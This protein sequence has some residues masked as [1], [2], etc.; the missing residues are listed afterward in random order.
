MPPETTEQDIPLLKEMEI[1]TDLPE[2]TTSKDIVPTGGIQIIGSSNNV[3]KVLLD[4][5]KK[6]T[7]C[8]SQDYKAIDDTIPIL[9]MITPKCNVDNKYSL[10]QL[11]T[12]SKY[13]TE[14]TVTVEQI[15]EEAFKERLEK[16]KHKFFEEEIKKCTRKI[17]TLLPEPCSTLKEFKTLYRDTCKANFLTVDIDKKISKIQ[18]EINQLAD[19]FI[20]SS[21]SLSVFEQ[22]IIGF[23]EELLKLERDKERIK[24]KAKDLK[25]KLSPKLDYLASLRKEIFDA[26]IQG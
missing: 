3:T 2:V 15:K 8:S 11:D 6:I 18:E 25:W 21:D 20:N 14:N 13:I 26:L 23:E 19:N 7:D 4:S 5:I 1:Q 10:S 12:L 22:K 16:E 17:D 24:G 9:K